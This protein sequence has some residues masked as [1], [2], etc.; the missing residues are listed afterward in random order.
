MPDNPISNPGVSPSTPPPEFG[1]EKPRLAE[2]EEAQE[3]KPF[4]L[5][6]EAGKE[7]PAEAVST[8][9]PTPMDVAKDAAEKGAPQMTPEQLGEQM[10]K[11]KTQLGTAQTNLQDSGITNKFSKDHYDALGKLVEK[12]N[13][14]MRSIAKS[15]KGELSPTQHISGEPVLKFITRWINGSQQTLSAA[16]NYIGSEKNPNPAS[17]LKL[18]YSVQR[19]TQR[20]ELFASIVG[21]TV[22]GIKTILS[23]QLG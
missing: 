10:D 21:A 9:K 7:Q 5:P 18:Q 11:L 6:P 23:T 1:R 13:P 19:A 17:M 3:P 22:S 14:D 20:G 15:T 4:A 12:M 2:G 16:M 8:D